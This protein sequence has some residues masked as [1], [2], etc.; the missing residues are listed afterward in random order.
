[1]MVAASQCDGDARRRGRHWLKKRLRRTHTYPGVQHGAN[2]APKSRP[3]HGCQSPAHMLAPMH[4]LTM[5]GTVEGGALDFGARVAGT[6]GARLRPVDTPA[7][8]ACP[9][10]PGSFVPC[11]PAAAPDV[12]VPGCGGPGCGA[13]PGLRGEVALGQCRTAPVDQDGGA[14]VGAH[15]A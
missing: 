4:G 8:S 14:A 11:F 5:N 2:S 7:T 15:C 1:M 6:R 9:G 10:C 3:P 13:G 12:L